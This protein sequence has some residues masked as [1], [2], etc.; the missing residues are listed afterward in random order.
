MVN[1]IESSIKPKPLVKYDR[2]FCQF[3]GV[4]SLSKLDQDL[5]FSVLSIMRERKEI[6][7]VISAKDLIARS[8][9][10]QNHHGGNYTTTA[11][12]S[13]IKKMAINVSKCTFIIDSPQAVDVI[14]LF[15]RFRV[16]KDT[17]DLTIVLAPTFSHIFFNIEST[18]TRFYLQQFLN[19]KSKYSKALYRLLLDHHRTFTISMGDLFSIFRIKNPNTQRQFLNRMPTYLKE[20]EATGDFKGDIRAEKISTKDSNNKKTKSIT[21]NFAENSNRVVESSRNELQNNYYCPYCHEVLV[22][23]HNKR[24]GSKFLGHINYKDCKCPVTTYPDVQA[25][26]SETEKVEKARIHDDQNLQRQQQRVSSV[27][28][29]TVENGIVLPDVSHL[30]PKKLA[31]ADLPQI[32]ETVIETLAA[33]KKDKNK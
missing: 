32:S 12:V 25:L 26:M 15:D 31:E 2:R 21:F 14:N 4:N 20:L 27:F 28:N 13:A 22:W 1:D 6:N 11:L 24:D 30:R 9:Y 7:T 33:L 17:G 3:S 19:L 16:D 10:L 18:F 29:G 5:F 23:R 8:E